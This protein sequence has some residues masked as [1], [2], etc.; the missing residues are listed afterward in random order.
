MI[1]RSLGS[2]HLDSESRILIY[3]GEPQPKS[4]TPGG[5]R[6]GGG[7]PKTFPR[8]ILPRQQ[9]KNKN[10]HNSTTKVCQ[11]LIFGI[12]ILIFDT[13]GPQIDHSTPESQDFRIIMFFFKDKP[14]K[15]KEKPCLKIG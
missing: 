11:R 15:T 12:F 13:P 8:K 10:L 5:G 14:P 9:K 3:L 1:L 4:W 2:G 6:G 7:S